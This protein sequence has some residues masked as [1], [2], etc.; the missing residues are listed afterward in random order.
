MSASSDGLWH[1]RFQDSVTYDYDYRCRV[2][3]RGWMTT[4][5]KALTCKDCKLDYADYITTRVIRTLE[6]G[7]SE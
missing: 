3:Y 6:F 4:D 7:S 5:P 1:L 2:C